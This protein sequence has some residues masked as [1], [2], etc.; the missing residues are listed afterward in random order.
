[1]RLRRGGKRQA[2]PKPP[3]RKAGEDYGTKA[4]RSAPAKIDE[5]LDA[6]LPVHCP[7]CAGALQLDKIE[8]QF[9]TEIPVKPI[10]RQFNVHVGHCSGCGKRVQGRHPLQTSDALGC[11]A[12]QLGPDAQA[13][14]VQLNK[15]AGLSHGKISNFFSIAFGIQLSRGG[16]CQAMLRSAGRCLP[17]YHRIL[18]HLPK[19]PWAVP[20]ETGWRVGGMS[21]W[22]HVA[23]TQDAV[24]FLIARQ[25]GIKATARLL[26][27]DYSG[28]LI[29]GGWAPYQRFFKARHQTCIAHLLR[30]SKEILQTARGGAVVFP[31]R[32][33]DI[34]QEALLTRDR[35]DAG[36]ITAAT[37]QRKAR[38]LRA[39]VAGLCEPAKTNAIN[40]RFAGHLYRQQ[41][42]LFTFLKRPAIDAT[43]YRAEQALRNPI[44]NRKVWGGS[45][46]PT[47]AA[48][49]S[50]LCS[51]WGTALKNA[52]QPFQWLSHL[53]CSPGAAPSLVP[54]TG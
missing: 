25:R 27:I 5:V 46:T 28:T 22:L 54:D 30:R 8:P 44:T 43:N 45:R 1:M 48:A 38:A 6:P 15:Q 14:I 36:D 3:G 51:I 2:D 24:A 12:S 32:I 52:T 39:R 53:L 41:H 37:A 21:H 18:A 16:V 11:C 13:A 42:H 7:L 9:Q 49:Q 31:R 20:D 26:P 35:R 29:H 4:H 17:Q 19:S 47:G 33:K 40:E 10:H 34:L 23:V 50:I